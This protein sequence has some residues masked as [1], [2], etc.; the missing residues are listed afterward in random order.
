[1]P[2]AKTIDSYRLAADAFGTAALE[3]LERSR[4]VANEVVIDG[5]RTETSTS[6]REETTAPR[7]GP[8]V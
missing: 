8:P 2:P 6:R 4:D 7:S 3:F 5:T 1:M